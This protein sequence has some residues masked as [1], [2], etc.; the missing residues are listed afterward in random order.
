[1]L[2]FRA[3]KFVALAIL[4][5]CLG[6][7]SREQQDW[8]SA[9]SADTVEGYA[10]FLK[11][12]PDSELVAEARTRFGQLS[13]DRE[14]Q[15]AGEADTADAYKQFLAQHPNGKWA[16]EARIRIENFAL[17]AE[18]TAATAAAA[19]N[20]A[21]GAAADASGSVVG[22]AATLP[23]GAA[24]F[25]GAASSGAAT[26]VSAGGPNGAPAPAGAVSNTAAGLAGTASNGAATGALAGS[27]A[28]AGSAVVSPSEMARTPTS[29]PMV[30]GEAAQIPTSPSAAAQVP[31][32]PSPA[33]YGYPQPAAPTQTPSAIGT[34]WRSAGSG[35]TAYGVQLGA[36]ASENAAASEWEQLTARFSAQLRGLVPHV[37]SAE[38]TTGHLFRLQALVPDE[39]TART[40]CDMLKKQSQACVPV[41]PH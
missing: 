5:V 15:R 2:T 11:Q 40:L 34:A 38:T 30:A 27:L 20:S 32:S 3:G 25:A 13:E 41:L 29:A 19:S 33:T 4:L 37:V 18:G 8:R 35:A 24:G 9:E 16:Q 39:A 1:M 23:N 14:W 36:F 12:H 22:P 21:A 10:R 6:A 26:G 17:G 7:C 28:A 31:T